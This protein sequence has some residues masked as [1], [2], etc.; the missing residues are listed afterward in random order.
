MPTHEQPPL[1]PNPHMLGLA[2]LYYPM[3][4]LNLN[5]RVIMHTVHYANSI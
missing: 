5:F 2:M 3:D 4:I 1:L